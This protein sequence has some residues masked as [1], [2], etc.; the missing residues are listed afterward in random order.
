MSLSS[1][2]GLEFGSTL[3]TQSLSL[4]AFSYFALRGNTGVYRSNKAGMEILRLRT[5][6]LI[7]QRVLLL[8]R[9][10]YGDSFRSL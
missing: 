9:S 8:Y 5:I 2:V 3:G 10:D 6:R 7:R 1:Y 4:A